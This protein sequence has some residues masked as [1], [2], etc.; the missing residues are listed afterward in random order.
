[1]VAQ[2]SRREC[3]S[4]VYIGIG[5][6]RNNVQRAVRKVRHTIGLGEKL[7]VPWSKRDEIKSQFWGDDT[8]QMMALLKYFMDRDPLASWRRIIVVLDMM[9]GYGGREAADK[10]RH[11]AEPVTGEGNG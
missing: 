11:L 4:F 2:S 10:I 7:G 9:R 6:A 5:F 8:E 3:L 1:M